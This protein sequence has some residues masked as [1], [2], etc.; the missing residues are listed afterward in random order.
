FH[1]LTD[2]IDTS[3]SA[4]RFFFHVMSALAQMERELIVERTKAG[5]AA[6]RSRGRIGGR[7]Y[8]LS[9]AQQEQARKLLESG[10]NRKQLALLY[11]VS[12]ASIYKY[13]PVNR[14]PRTGQ[15]GSDEK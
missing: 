13:C 15:S 2:A 7:P 10:N 12:L 1:S 8:S 3:T 11:G 14:D 5:L 9:S 6:A 4:G